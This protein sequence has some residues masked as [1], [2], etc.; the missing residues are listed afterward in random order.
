[1][2]N[3]FL[4][5]QNNSFRNIGIEI[6]KGRLSWIRLT[7]TLVT[8]PCSLLMLSALKTAL[9][10]SLFI[11]SKQLGDST[12][13]IPFGCKYKNFLAD[14]QDMNFFH[15]DIHKNCLK[16]THTNPTEFINLQSQVSDISHLFDWWKKLFPQR[17]IVL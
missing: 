12:K 3:K 15:S 13:F 6:Y 8:G 1:M 7:V 16:D 11:N 4:K 17:C 10:V 9:S 2:I 5:N 14:P